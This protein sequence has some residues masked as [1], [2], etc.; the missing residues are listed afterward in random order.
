MKY[1]DTS[2]VV[3]A[4]DPAD[5]SMENSIEIF[6]KPEKIISELAVIELTSA[7][8]RNRN[9]TALM[10]ELSGGRDSSSY[11]AITYIL[12]RF[13]LVYFPIPQ[14]PVETPIGKYNNIM[15]LA[16]ELS[17][18]VPMRTLDLLHLSYAYTISKL[19][20]S[21][22]EFITRDREFEVYNKEIHDATGIKIIYLA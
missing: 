5:P 9:F 15:A 8:L 10:D 6:R 19:T 20:S 11:A 13:D 12:E 14:N 7:L 21:K 3:S 2:V 1:I 17:Y 22:I 4:L 16:I 18:K